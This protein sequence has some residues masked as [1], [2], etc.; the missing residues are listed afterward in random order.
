[1]KGAVPRRLFAMR[2][3]AGALILA[4]VVFAVSLGIFGLPGVIAPAKAAGACGANGVLTSPE[5]CTYTTVGEDTFSVP[6]DVTAVHVTLVGGKGGAGGGTFLGTHGGPGGF[7]AAVTADIPVSAESLYVEVGGNGSGL[8]GGSTSGGA[9]G[10]ATFALG[11]GGGAASDIRT[12]ADAAGPTSLSSRLVVAAGGG[13][14]G[15]G[16]VPYYG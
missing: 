5:T 15:G 1:M 8:T 16:G 7:G 14:G 12:V 4:P 13:G 6:T 3:S 9:G 2:T 10:S 11:A